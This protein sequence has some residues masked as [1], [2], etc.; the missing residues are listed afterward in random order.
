M[1]L[2][3]LSE[4]Y[5]LNL[6]DFIQNSFSMF[7]QENKITY[8]NLS[9]KL[10]NEF[11]IENYL[12]K[13]NIKLDFD[14]LNKFQNLYDSNLS[15]K[16]TFIKF[17][18]QV[19][20][21]NE[22]Q[23]FLAAKFDEN[24]NKYILN[25]Y[26]NFNFNQENLDFN[27]NS[28]FSDRICLEVSNI[29][30]LNN[31]I[32]NEFSYNNNFSNIEKIFVYDYSNKFTKIN[33][34]LLILGVAYKENNFIYIHAWKIFDNYFNFKFDNLYNNIKNVDF[35]NLIYSELKEKILNNFN[36]DELLANY[37]ILFLFSHIFSRNNTLIIGNFPMNI[38]L[39]K[40]EKNSEKIDFISN[41]FSKISLFFSHK[42]LSI[43]YLNEK[44][45]FPIFNVDKEELSNSDIKL[46]DNSI[47]L[48][49][50]LTMTEGKL[51][52]IGLKN[53]AC[54]KNLIDFQ[55]INYQYPFNN[56]E[57]NHD[58][59]II[60]FSQKTKSIL[61]S[62]FLTILPQN[63][64]ENNNNNNFKEDSIMN[65]EN[66]I[67]NLF[68]YI[69][70]VRLNKKEFI[71]SNEINEQICKNFTEKNKGKFKSENLN[72]IMILSRLFALSNGRNEL[73]YS[74]YE[75]AYNLEEKRLE[76][77]EYLKTKLK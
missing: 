19:E 14:S 35:N 11:E 77:I 70:Y 3:N 40:N 1:S 9:N 13:N 38:I 22:N 41:L 56:I 24:N 69:N 60:I 16:P 47:L 52:Q 20:N 63:S 37:L 10:I 50:E 54:I 51:Q 25:K 59:Q 39:E 34:N 67:K 15:Q 76:R 7:L 68:I 57:I 75:F 65:D 48:I 74:D 53:F 4:I 32:A 28:I 42:N 23:L 26:Y 8:P 5:N 17:L 21:I 44:P 66:F 43:S 64:N 12:T 49:N 55:T 61:N 45:L 71:I 73:I 30:N 29:K 58:I 33:N 62:P 36:N 31:F 6:N 27:K 46:C 72:K 2:N 18:C